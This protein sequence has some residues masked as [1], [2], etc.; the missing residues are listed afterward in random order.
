MPT[1][2]LIPF[3]IFF[4]CCASQF[5]FVKRV[6]DRLIDHHPNVFLK[7]ERASFFPHN[8]IWRYAFDSRFRGLNDPELDRRV[9]NLR[10]LT[11]IAL[12]SWLAIAVCMVTMPR[13]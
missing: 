4:I 9:R 13:A 8:H 1:Y 10:I 5:W 2:F 3:A 11:A 12:G 6:R 7:Q